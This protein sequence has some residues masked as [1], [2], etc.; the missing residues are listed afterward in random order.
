MKTRAPGRTGIRVSPY[1]RTLEHL[2]D[3]LAGPEVTVD[4]DV[5]DCID[6]IAAPGCDIGPLDVSCT[7]PALTHAAL[8]R[9]PVGER[10]A[11]SR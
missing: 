8:R 10:A 6:Q 7:T 2:D 11:V 9:R 3:L 5:L 4:E 1:C